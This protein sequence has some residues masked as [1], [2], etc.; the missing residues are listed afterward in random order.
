LAEASSGEPASGGSWPAAAIFPPRGLEAGMEAIRPR[1]RTVIAAD[2]YPLAM[3]TWPAAGAK[4]RARVVVLH[5]VQSHAGWYHG[6]GRRLAAAGIEAHFPDRRGSG[7]NQRQRGHT[8]ASGW[9]I[10][11]VLRVLADVA[12]GGPAAGRIPV[13]LAGISWGGK[14]VVTAAAA[15]GHKPLDGIALICPG[16][17]PRVGVSRRERLRIVGALVRG[18]R[19]TATFPIPLA[20]PALFTADP[21]ARAFIAADPLSLREA[22]AGLLAASFFLDRGVRRA[23]EHVRVPALLMLA[24]QDRIVD[25]ARTEAYFA[26]LASPAR[27][28]IRYPDAHHTLEFEPDPSRYVRDLVAWIETAVIPSRL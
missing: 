1:T 13:V 4:P 9:L 27:Q 3:L 10:E 11:D 2:G 18:R 26:Q 17:T 8:P 23:P 5:G 14:L 24:G 19:E 25:N 28:V 21:E 15:P 16:L 22:T 7:A 20:D 12:G 6:L